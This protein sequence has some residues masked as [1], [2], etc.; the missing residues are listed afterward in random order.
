MER[1]QSA[2][3]RLHSFEEPIDDNTI[4]LESLPSTDSLPFLLLTKSSD[5]AEENGIPHPSM[6]RQRKV[7]QGSRLPSDGSVASSGG[8]LSTGDSITSINQVEKL[9]PLKRPPSASLFFE[10]ME[11]ESSSPE[12][13]YLEYLKTRSL[14]YDK[15]LPQLRPPPSASLLQGTAASSLRR[16]SL[17]LASPVKDTIAVA[18]PVR[19]VVPSASL[20]SGTAASQKRMSTQTR[21]PTTTLPSPGRDATPRRHSTPVKRFEERD[22][23]QYRRRHSTGTSASPLQ[24]PGTSPTKE[25]LQGRRSSATNTTTIKLPDA[26]TTPKD[27]MYSSLDML[28]R[29]TAAVTAKAVSRPTLVREKR[30]IV[31]DKNASMGMNVRLPIGG[32]AGRIIEVWRGVGSGSDESVDSTLS[33]GQKECQAKIMKREAAARCIIR[34][35]LRQRAKRFASLT[36]KAPIIHIS[37]FFALVARIWR[38]RRATTILRDFLLASYTAKRTTKLVSTDEGYRTIL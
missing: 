18:S 12:Q 38:K 36:A 14:P 23:S 20:L 2:M 27:H 1:S 35:F 28:L 31:P 22:P 8:N 17:T 21:S 24:F 5:Q 19:S 30:D 13:S 37:R 29:K 15:N 32:T 25:K 33:F 26:I 10:N 3:L 11:T 6:S 9:Q 16:Q 34:M 4:L 7:I